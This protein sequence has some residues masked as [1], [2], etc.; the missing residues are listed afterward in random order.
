MTRRAARVDANQTE[1][2]EA[3]RAVGC[4]VL[5]LAAIG[6]GVPDLLVWRRGLGYVLIEVKDG[7]KA[8]S[9]Q[10]LTDDQ[11]RFHDEWPGPVIIANSVSAALRAV[12]VTP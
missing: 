10:A 7:N 5:S 8:P 1:I 4:A 2:V 6:K 12:G 9:R 3:L 11:A